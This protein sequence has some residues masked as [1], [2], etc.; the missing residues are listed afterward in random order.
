VLKR[1]DLLDFDG[2]SE[3]KAYKASGARLADVDIYGDNMSKHK[4]KTGQNINFK[5]LK[6]KDNK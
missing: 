2:E 4:S 6:C 5:A 1:T 3:R